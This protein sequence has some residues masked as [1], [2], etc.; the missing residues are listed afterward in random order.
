VRKTK[1]PAGPR[2]GGLRHHRAR[3]NKQR[4]KPGRGTLEPGCEKGY[5]DVVKSKKELKKTRSGNPGRGVVPK[6][7]WVCKQEIRPN[8]E[9][10][11]YSKKPH[12]TQIAKSAKGGGGHERKERERGW[13]RSPEDT[14]TARKRKNRA[15]INSK[16]KQEQRGGKPK[17]KTRWSDSGNQSCQGGKDRTGTVKK[18]K[19]TEVKKELHRLQ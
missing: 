6:R 13:G 18:E 4:E 5:R 2:G 14:T 11:Q 9:S 12:C 19:P 15:L 3:R 10:K 7:G 1:K 17:S 8:G 16:K